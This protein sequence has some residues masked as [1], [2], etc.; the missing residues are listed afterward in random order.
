MLITDRLVSKYNYMAKRRTKRK[1]KV[2]LQDYLGKVR[3]L[4]KVNESIQLIQEGMFGEY[5]LPVDFEWRDKVFHVRDLIGRWVITDDENQEPSR[6]C[7]R[8]DLDDMS[9]VDFCRPA[10]SDNWLIIGVEPELLDVM[11]KNK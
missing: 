11:R 2:E 7:Y 3:D 5:L 6:V 8:V 1:K 9:Q 10:E 4:R